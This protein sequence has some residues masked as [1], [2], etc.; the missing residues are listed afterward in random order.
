MSFNRKVRI[1][2]HCRREGCNGRAFVGLVERG[3]FHCAWCG[4]RVDRAA[5]CSQVR[6]Q[7]QQEAREAV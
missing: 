3:E 6:Q 7:Q 1:I 5:V 2:I 4:H